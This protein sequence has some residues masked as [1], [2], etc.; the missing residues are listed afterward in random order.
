MRSAMNK[1]N[2]RG[3]RGSPWRRPTLEEK[4]CPNLEPNLI[5]E[6]VLT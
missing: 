1:I 3:E 4:G 5:L 2:R 6:V